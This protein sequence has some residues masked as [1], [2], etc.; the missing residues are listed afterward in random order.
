MEYINILYVLIFSFFLVLL[1]LIITYYFLPKDKSLE[2]LSA[3]ECGFNPFNDVSGQINVQFY[4]VSIL[5]ILFDLEIMF[6]F[7]WCL[8]LKILDFFSFIVIFYFLF[9]LMIGFFYEWV[10]GALDWD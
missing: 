9:I 2:K 5:F 8:S 7:P 1:L 6:L 4:S 3:Y 10:S